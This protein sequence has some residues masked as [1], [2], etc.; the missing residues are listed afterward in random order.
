MGRFLQ[1]DP[2]SFRAGDANLY[3]FIQNSLGNATDPNG[4]TALVEYAVLGLQAAVGASL[5]EAVSCALFRSQSLSMSSIGSR[6]LTAL[7]PTSLKKG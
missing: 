6:V 5:A 3:R 1:V 7:S 2:Y 4:K